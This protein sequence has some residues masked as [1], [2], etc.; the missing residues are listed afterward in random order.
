MNTRSKGFSPS[1][2]VVPVGSTV[3]F[4]NG[5]PILH[6]VYSDSPGQSFD[7]GLYG[8]GETRE[9]RFDRTGL[10]FVHCNVHGAMQANIV[11]L[12][13]PHFTRAGTDGYFVLEGVAAGP[14][15][16]V[17]WHPRAEAFTQ[18]L[19]VPADGPLALRLTASKP[20]L[21]RQR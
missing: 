6:N 9:Q 15:T 3:V 18:A 10:V 7:L 13:T 16:L 5:D 12:D 8:E 4:P 19:A 1:L 20:R 14:G 2:L 11:V 21:G 17:V